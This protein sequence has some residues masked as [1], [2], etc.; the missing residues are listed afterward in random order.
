MESRINWRKAKIGVDIKSFLCYYINMMKKESESM[1]CTTNNPFGVSY[2]DLDFISANFE[3]L[4]DKIY[5]KY[6]GELKFVARFKNGRPGKGKFK[7]FFKN[8]FTPK[9][10]FD[11]YDNGRGLPPLA[12]LETKG[13]ESPITRR[14]NAGMYLPSEETFAAETTFT[15]NGRIIEK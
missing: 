9:E 12:I 14:L 10:Y 4:G 2:G 15:R 11:L 13:Y 1:T 5:Y 3:N 8:N 6:L 7:K